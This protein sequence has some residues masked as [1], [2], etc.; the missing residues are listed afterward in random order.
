MAITALPA[1]PSRS[2]PTNFATKAD[3]W[4]AALDTFTSEANALQADVN[5][6]QTTAS[7][8]ATNASN[9]AAAAA[10]S[11]TTALNA[12]GTTATSTSSVT[13]ASG[14]KSLV[15]AQTG[16]AF[17]VGMWVT[18]SDVTTPGQFITGP[19]VA[20]NSG[21]GAMDITAMTYSGS[22]SSTNWNIS[23][24]TPQSIQ[25]TQ[26]FSVNLGPLI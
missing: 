14:S 19:I 9:S 20:F 3:L 10:A 7:T 1:A 4:V 15:L 24:A 12:P 17:A 21:T 25:A 26:W 16:K 2:D 22:G 23:L 5:S 13:L 8:A 18:L 11:A 6:K